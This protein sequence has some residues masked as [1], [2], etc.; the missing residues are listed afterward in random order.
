[1]ATVTVTREIVTLPRLVPKKDEVTRK[2]DVL[3]SNCLLPI[4]VQF[5]ID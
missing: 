2:C 4:C 5:V 3:S 1:M